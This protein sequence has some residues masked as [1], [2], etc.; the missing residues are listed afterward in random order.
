MMKSLVYGLAS[1]LAVLASAASARGVSPYLPLNLEPEMEAQIERVL[2]LAERPVMSRP[3]AAA[4][5]LDALP[6]ASKIDPALCERVRRY[7]ERYEHNWGITH[8]SVEGAAGSGRGASTVA[9]NRYGMREDSHWDASAQVY[10]QPS[11]YALLDLGAVGYEGHTDYT[12]SLLSLG[13]SYA[14]LDIG[15]RPHWFSP[16]TDSSMLMSTEAP[17][18]PS[19]TLS[20][21][22]QFSPFGLRYE[23][24]AARMSNSNRIVYGDGYTSGH[25]RLAGIHID[26]EPATGWSLGI[27]RLMQYGGGLRGGG[28]LG[29]LF[30]A[31]F[32]PSGFDNTSP[33]LTTSQTVGNQ[34]ASITSS[35]LF[36][37]RVPFSVYVEYAGEDTSRGKNYLLGNSSLSWGVHFPRLWERF[38]FTYEINEW[39]NAWYV[40]SVYLDGLTNYGRVIGNWFGDQ[41]ITGDGV[42]GRSQMAALGWDTPFGGLLQLRYRTLQNQ[43]YGEFP[44]K[45]FH[46]FELGYS[47]P[48]AGAV[49]GA[50]LDAGRDVFGGNFTRLAGYIR[51]D[52]GASLTGAFADVLGSDGTEDKKGE[53][54]VDVGGNVNRQNIDLTSATTRY[55]G[56]YG[57]GYH[58]AFGARRFVSDH[59]DLGTRLEVDGIQGNNLLGVRLLDYRYRFNNPLALSFFL[60]AARY[61]LVTPAYGIYYGAGLQWRNLMPGWDLAFDYRYA[62]SVARDHLV[63]GDPPDIGARS[64]SFYNISSWTFAVSR[65]F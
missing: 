55:N 2:I 52:E 48:L 9:P 59:S 27:S 26:M 6:K 13:G 47:R 58:F 28:S 15:Y 36:P 43:V 24:F 46:E 39:Q 64:D 11:D 38:D 45:R 51:Y 60:G 42:G 56:P 62:N 12:G 23:L 50:E 16:L 40:H 3:I 17:T 19:V 41:R 63:P 4:T 22:Q 53:L 7:L 54:F 32:N 33:T 20:N 14:Q 18:M 34:E 61:N 8:A 44:Y 31:F 49:V 57:G 1:V 29:D 30:R 21:Y 35:L 5:V 37:G 65:H 10:W 25:P